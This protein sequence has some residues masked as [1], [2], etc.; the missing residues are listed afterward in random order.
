MHR[1]G[2]PVTVINHQTAYNL[3]TYHLGRR[4]DPGA[5]AEAFLPLNALPVI[6]F[7]GPGKLA[8]PYFRPLQPAQVW[9]N[10]QVGIAGIG[11]IAFAGIKL[12]GLTD[13]SQFTDGT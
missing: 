6:T 2:R 12:Q 4:F 1:G 3:Y 13:P 7:N 8:R 5:Q 11:G 9:F 10:Q